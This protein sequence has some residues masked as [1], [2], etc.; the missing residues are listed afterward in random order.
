MKP[1]FG[2]NGLGDIRFGYNYANVQDL[3]GIRLNADTN[4]SDP[5]RWGTPASQAASW[6]SYASPPA[7]LAANNPFRPPE[8]DVFVRALPATAPEPVDNQGS[9]LGRLFRAA[10]SPLEHAWN[11]FVEMFS[12]NRSHDHQHW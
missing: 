8:N 11:W 12:P 6:A 2:S 5:Y 7:V 4:P 10:I 3:G 1:V 9:A